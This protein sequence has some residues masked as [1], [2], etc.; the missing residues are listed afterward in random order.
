[1]DFLTARKVIELLGL[2]PHP[3]GGFFKETFRDENTNGGRGLST[4]IYFLLPEGIES[5]WHKVDAAEVWHWYAGS[6][7]D[8]YIAEQAAPEQALVLG[9]DLAS[10]ERPQ[11]VVPPNGWQKAKS[12]GDWTLVGCTVAPAFEFSS[13]ELAPSDWS[14]G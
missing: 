13:F 6:A 4:A 8:L 5:A 12:R 11:A 14:P 3:E 10:G 1:M 2:E 7:L 9:P